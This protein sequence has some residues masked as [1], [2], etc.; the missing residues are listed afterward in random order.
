VKDQKWHTRANRRK[1]LPLLLSRDRRRD[2]ARS[3][4]ALLHPTVVQKKNIRWMRQK[5]E[6]P[7]KLSESR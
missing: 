1:R 3:A 7:W 5:T 6:I 4:L 2:R